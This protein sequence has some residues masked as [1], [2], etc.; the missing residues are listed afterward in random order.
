MVGIIFPVPS[1]TRSRVRR[2][3][4]F[5]GAEESPASSADFAVASGYEDRIHHAPSRRSPEGVKPDGAEER[6]WFV[7]PSRARS[8]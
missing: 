4:H 6:A 7:S 1:S 2:N 3:I 5:I 8:P